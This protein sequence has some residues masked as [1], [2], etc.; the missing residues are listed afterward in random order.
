MSRLEELILELC[1]DGVEYK[2]LGEI[3]TISR[4]G[5]LQKKDFC[6]EG[7]PCIHYGQ[8]YTRY[9]L[10]ADKT[11]SFISEDRAK[12][13]KMAYTNDIV[14]AVTSENIEDVCKC[15]AWLG[16]GEIAVSGHTAI[17]HHNQ[18]AK[19]LTY[20]FHTEMFA[21]QKRKLV[22]GTKVM[23]ITPDTL[24]TVVLPVPPLPVQCEIV[25]ILNNFTELTAELTAKLTA[26]LAAR[27]KQY[28]YYR[29][30]LLSFDDA[31]NSQNVHVER[32]REREREREA[33]RAVRWVT[34]GEIATDM[35]RGSGI[36]RNEITPDGIPCVRY[37]E[38]YTT[39]GVWFNKCVSHTQIE[40]VTSPKYFSHGDIL[41][42]ITGE[43]VNEIAKSC[44]YLGNDECLAGGDIVVMKHEQ[45]P[46]YLAYALSTTDAQKQKSAGKV[47]SKVVHSS[48]PAIQS[49]KIPL[50]PLAEQQRIVSILDRFDKLCNNISE[51]LPAEITA[52]QKQYE[53]YR[54]KLL[55][56]KEKKRHE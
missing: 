16:E 19:Y 56:F 17:I 43:N 12:K 52:R 47:K 35:Y 33:R 40:R 10:F 25:C 29:N 53:Y 2:K 51:G 9:G 39:Y 46:K 23:E 44:A 30:L 37:G 50:P 38:I 7:V 11:F 42:A 28:E 31:N 26:E 22:H 24:N 54:D 32:E 15:V 21:V 6:T 8:I 27:Q 5:N 18:N 49:I 4:G 36:K 41:F 34:L 20:Y 55:T 13:Q 1:P 45:N 14:M 3:A 48:I